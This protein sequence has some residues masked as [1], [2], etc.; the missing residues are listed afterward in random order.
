MERDPQKR[1]IGEAR[2]ALLMTVLFVIAAVVELLADKSAHKGSVPVLLGLAIAS[3]LR[4]YQR[5]KAPLPTTQPPSAPVSNPEP[6]TRPQRNGPEDQDIHMAAQQILA[7][8]DPR[9]QEPQS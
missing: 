2:L 3:S 6:T 5:W 9:R 4:S 1:R 7:G 8:D